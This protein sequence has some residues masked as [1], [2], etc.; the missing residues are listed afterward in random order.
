MI[1]TA[2]SFSFLSLLSFPRSRSAG[3]G[4]P[5]TMAARLLGDGAFPLFCP[6][7]AASVLPVAMLPTAALPA[8]RRQRCPGRVAAPPPRSGCSNPDGRDSPALP[9]AAQAGGAPGVHEVMPFSAGGAPACP[10]SP[11]W[12]RLRAPTWPRPYR[13][14]KRISLVVRLLD[15]STYP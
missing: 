1:Y 13:H 9:A 11:G 5:S 10:E 7:R 14:P 12:W 4:S 2:L 3:H 15:R 6:R 8:P